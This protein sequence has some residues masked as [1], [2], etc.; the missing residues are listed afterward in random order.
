MRIRDITLTVR[1]L[2]ECAAFY[3][4]VLELLVDEQSD[5]ATVRIGPSR[6]VLRPGERYTGVHHLAFGVSPHEFVRTHEWLGQRVKIWTINGSEVFPGPPGWNSRS[7]YFFGPEEMILEYIAHD[8]DAVHSVGTGPSPNL[9][10]IYEI[11]V[12]VPD[13]PAAV[14]E[15]TDGFGLA[16]FPPQTSTVAPQTSTFAPVGDHDGRFI[17]VNPA[18]HWLAAP[19][20]FPAPSAPIKATIDAPKHPDG[21]TTLQSTMIYAGGGPSTSAAAWSGLQ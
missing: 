14:A 17:L 7:L 15:L 20:H 5:H 10:G 8:V 11:G 18:R 12:A 3:R 1:D 9:L 2:A 13:V 19:D 16:P 4:D 6:L 21:P